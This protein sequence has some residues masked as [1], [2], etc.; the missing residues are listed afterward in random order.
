MRITASTVHQRIVSGCFY[1]V[2]AELRIMTGI[3]WTA[4]PKTLITWSF[5][6]NLSAL[7][8]EYNS[9]HTILHVSS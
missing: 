1:A 4:K 3:V 2:R 6:E 7:T 5:T 9:L 8:V